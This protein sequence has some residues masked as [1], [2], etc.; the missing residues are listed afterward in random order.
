MI[1][2]N[3]TK[4]DIL[5]EQICNDVTKT[6]KLKFEFLDARSLSLCYVTYRYEGAN[7]KNLQFLQVTCNIYSK[8]LK[9]FL[10]SLNLFFKITACF[11]Q[12]FSKIVL[13][14]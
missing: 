9:I 11:S 6:K 12:K 7:L 8:L 3:S 2:K 10:N 14:I 5:R 1:R 13:K 4:S